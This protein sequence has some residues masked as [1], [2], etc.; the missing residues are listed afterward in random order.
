MLTGWQRLVRF[1]FHLLYNQMAWT[2]DWVSWLVS[3][4][5]W[6]HWQLAALPYLGQPDMGN[7]RFILEIGHGPGHMLLEL[8]EVEKHVIGL[9]LSPHMGRMTQKR[10]QKAGLH[11]QLTQGNVQELPFSDSTF[12]TVLSTFPTDFIVD[13]A[14]LTAVHRV[15]KDNGRFVIIPAAHL[16]GNGMIHRL[17]DSLF[18][19]T[20]QKKGGMEMEEMETAVWQPLQQ[21]F[22]RVGFE[23]MIKQ[24]QRP[25]SSI[26][27]I[28]AQKRQPQ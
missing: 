9:D 17:I 25:H 28:M 2:Y 15:L 13:P 27:L 20:G 16:T 10:L 19:L 23:T 11:A 3:L 24:I 14:T 18:R 6:R 4:G 21:Q 7:G 8:A 5:E 22:T 12:D 1:G 26:T